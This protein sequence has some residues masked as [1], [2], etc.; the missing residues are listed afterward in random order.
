MHRTSSGSS[1]DIMSALKIIIFVSSFISPV[2]NRKVMQSSVLILQA[3]CWTIGK[4]FVRL[5]YN[6][7]K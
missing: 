6:K 4:V 2:F 5:F 7:A 1:F 3:Y